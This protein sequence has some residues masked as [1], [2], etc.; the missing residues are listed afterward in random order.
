MKKNLLLFMTA[1]VLLLSCNKHDK[2]AAAENI[3]SNFKKPSSADSLKN[4]ENLKLEFTG[5]EKFSIKNPKL[6]VSLYGHDPLLADTPAT[7]ITEQEYEETSI[8]FTINMPVPK[9]AADRIDPKIKDRIK[10][11]VSIEW[12]S[13]GN[14]KASEKRDIYIDHDKEFPNVKLN[15]EPQKIYLKILK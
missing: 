6:K 14:G 15:G 1:G 13:D 12:D 5:S 8:P 11:Y 10:Y 7:L 4:S 2:K 3:Q 9:D